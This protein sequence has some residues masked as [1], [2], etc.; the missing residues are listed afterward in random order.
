MRTYRSESETISFNI[1]RKTCEFNKENLQNAILFC[2]FAV[3]NGDTAHARQF[4]Q[5]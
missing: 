3:E 1:C 4:K 5:V 2:I